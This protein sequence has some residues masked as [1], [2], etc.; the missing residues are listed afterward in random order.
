MFLLAIPVV[1]AEIDGQWV[2]TIKRAD[3]SKLDMRYRFKAEGNT[4]IGLLESRLG[5]GSISGGKI[6]GNTIEFRIT[7]NGLNIT[8][9]GTLSGD[10][11]HLTETL[12]TQETKFVLKRVRYDK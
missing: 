8:N 5:N 11:I 1:C 3:G 4:L 12:G 10:E 6:D 9:T 7:A 2:G